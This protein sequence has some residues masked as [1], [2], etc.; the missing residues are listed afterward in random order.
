MNIEITEVSAF[1]Y[2]A[3]IKQGRLTDFEY[4]LI[5]ACYSRSEERWIGTVDG[6]VACLWGLIPPT[7]MSDRAYLW[8]YNNELVDEHKFAFIRHS[9]VQMKRMLKLYPIIV[10]DCLIS[11]DSGRQWLRWLGATFGPPDGPLA[12]F[13]IKAKAYG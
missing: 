6:V 3:L 13:E 7:L 1:D 5:G 2:R 4:N 8:L 11:N 9:Q 12:P 10:G